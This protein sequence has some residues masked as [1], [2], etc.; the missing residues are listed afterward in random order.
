MTIR[1]IQK[2]P[3]WWQAQHEARIQAERARVEAEMAALGIPQEGA[4]VV[5]RQDYSKPGICRHCGRTLRIVARGICPG[6]HRKPEV[7]AMYQRKQR[8]ATG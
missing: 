1:H 5:S 4:D 2:C 6:C 7:R 3:A 8:R